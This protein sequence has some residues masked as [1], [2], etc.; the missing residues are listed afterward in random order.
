MKVSLERSLEMIEN[1]PNVLTAWL[2]SLSDDWTT[3]NEGEN[4]WTAKEVVAHLIVCEETDWLPRARIILSAEGNKTLAPIDM[5]AH[6]RIAES[7]SLPALLVRF[8]QLRVNG[9][10]ELKA[11]DLQEEDFAKTANHPVIGAVNLEQLIAAWAAHDL[12]H[13]AQI[14]R[15]MARQNKDSV[16]NFKKYLRIL[17]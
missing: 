13:I 2:S 8:R 4:T 10:D 7:S 12:S 11:F 14:A 15:I 3:N 1:T 9:V 5:A 16:G 17:N 6:F